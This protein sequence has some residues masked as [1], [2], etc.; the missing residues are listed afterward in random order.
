MDYS[1]KVLNFARQ[2]YNQILNKTILEAKNFG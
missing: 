2:R 1:I